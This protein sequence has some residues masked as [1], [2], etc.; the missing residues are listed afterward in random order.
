VAGMQF[1]RGYLTQHFINNAKDQT[2]VL[3]NVS[4]VITD[5]TIKSS[6]QVGN[7]INSLHAS[8]IN[9]IL[10]IAEDVEQHLLADFVLNTKKSQINILAVKAPQHGENRDKMLEDIAALT[11]GSVISD[12]T[13][14]SFQTV[15]LS[16]VGKADKVT[17]SKFFTTIVGGKG[18]KE[19]IEKRVLQ[20][21]DNIKTVETERGRVLLKNRL[22]AMSGGIAVIKVGAPTDVDTKN[23]V[24]K[25]E[26]A[27]NAT[28][29]ALEEG[30]VQG[31]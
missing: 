27:I 15:S 3:E 24:Y 14:V 16:D 11:G 31:G 18:K 19:D 6:Q 4:V 21:K 26:D 2:C 23:K 30:V 7:I 1:S 20:I 5:Q 12:K 10:F 9:N 22:A 13:G 8:G 17:A 29:S 25:I 28:K